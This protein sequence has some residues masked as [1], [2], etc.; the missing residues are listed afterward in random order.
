MYDDIFEKYPVDPVVYGEA[1]RLSGSAVGVGVTNVADRIGDAVTGLASG[2]GGLFRS[3]RPGGRAGG[4]PLDGG[5]GRAVG[6][7]GNAPQGVPGRES[8][9]RR[10]TSSR[11]SSS[12]TASGRSSAMIRSSATSTRGCSRAGDSSRSDRKSRRLSSAARLAGTLSA[13]PDA[14]HWY[15]LFNPNDKAFTAPIRLNVDNFTRVYAA[16]NDGYINH[17]A[18][19]YLSHANTIDSVCA[20][21]RRRRRAGW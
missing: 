10:R 17:D 14:L 13:L 21:W 16:F 1:L 2:I 5:H 12:P 4:A 8:P 19:H 18:V 7:R 15:Q 6:E 9:G 20:R 11:T 3:A